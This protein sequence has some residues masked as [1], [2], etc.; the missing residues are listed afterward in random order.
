MAITM[1]SSFAAFNAPLVSAAEA[2]VKFYVSPNGDDTEDGSIEFPFRTFQKAKQSVSEYISAN[3]IPNGGIDVIFREGKYSLGNTGFDLSG[4]SGSNG[5]YITFKAY[6]GEE[7]ILDGSTKIPVDEITLV[8]DQALLDRMP[9][10]VRGKVYCVDLSALGIITEGKN[11]VPYYTYGQSWQPDVEFYLNDTAMDIARWPNGHEKVNFGMVMDVGEVTK[12]DENGV[13]AYDQYGGECVFQFDNDRIDRW[14]N[15]ENIYAAGDWS[16]AWAQHSLKVN[17]I[18]FNERT[19]TA[20]GARPFGIRDVHPIFFYNM[21]EELDQKNEFYVNEAENKFY[22][23]TDGAVEDVELSYSTMATQAIKLKGDYL[24]IQGFTIQNVAGNGIYGSK[25]H[26]NSEA[27]YNIEVIN[28]TIR[29]VGGYGIF[30]YNAQNLLVCDNMV[31]NIGRDGI[32]DMNSNDREAQGFWT[33]E[34]FDVEVSNNYICNWSRYGFSYVKAIGAWLQ[35][36]KIN[37]NTIH[38]SAHMVVTPANM[39]EFSYNEVYDVARDC[40][41]SGI[42]YSGRSWLGGATINNNYFHGDVNTKSQYSGIYL[43][44]AMSNVIM[45]NNIFEN[46]QTAAALSGINNTFENNII[47][48]KSKN[49]TTSISTDNRLRWENH[50]NDIQNGLNQVK[51]GLI[52]NEIWKKERPWLYEAVDE[53]FQ[54]KDEYCNPYIDI[55]NNILMQAAPMNICAESYQYGEIVNNY[56]TNERLAFSDYKNG[57]FTLTED[58]LKDYPG[59]KP[60]DFYSIGVQPSEYNSL[61]LAQRRLKD[62]VVLDIDN[63]NAFVDN[64][65]VMIDKDNA[66]VVPTIID[67]RTLVPLRFIAEA[68]GAEVGWNGETRTVSILKGKTDIKMVIGENSYTLNGKKYEM[69]VPAQV[70][71]DRTMVPVRVI[72]ESLNQ[73]VFWDAEGLVIIGYRASVWDSVYDNYRIHTIFEALK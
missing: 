53:N 67:G 49:S 55:K 60:I 68:F 47:I 8:T 17:S 19:I 48:G 1:L 23:M 57:D 50:R 39:G 72:S 63:P 27:M 14:K 2:T 44:D 12:K 70:L 58:A 5:N 21:I 11:V 42:V 46:L 6:D 24:R 69:D 65:K 18:D 41:D 52:N 7:A 34:K 38:Q 13:A 31:Y 16:M 30:L 9:E 3:G 40:D 43:D 54:I 51:D 37:N 36:S 56:E 10:E 73:E 61:T 4:L 15:A 25:E 20:E 66:S 22:F 29:N 35:G 62:C 64:K 71:N 26:P 59:V 28:N 33:L 32:V 45:T